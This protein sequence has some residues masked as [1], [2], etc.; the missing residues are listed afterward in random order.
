VPTASITPAVAIAR[1]LALD[2]GSRERGY[3]DGYAGV[4]GRRDAPDLLAYASGYV[5]GDFDRRHQQHKRSNGMFHMHCDACDAMWSA[6]G[7]P[8]LRCPDCGSHAV[9]QDEDAQSS[10][11]TRPGYAAM[12]KRKVGAR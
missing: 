9:E 7:G 3:A 4:P 5:E 11:P 12:P 2:P 8:S 1:G 6:L 10:R